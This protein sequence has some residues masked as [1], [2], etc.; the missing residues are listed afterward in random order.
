[1]SAALNPKRV[2]VSGSTGLIGRRLTQALRE[3]GA[4]VVPLLRRTDEHGM[5]SWHVDAGA[6]GFAS[7]SGFDAVVHLAGEPVATGR[8]TARK[9]R[10]IFSSRVQGTESLVAALLQA[11]EPPRAFLCASGIN[12]YGDRGDALLDEA[13]PRGA[14]FLADVCEHWEAATDPL[15]G[16]CRVVLLRI[17]VVLAR[18]G[19]ALRRCCCLSGLA[20]AVAWGTAACT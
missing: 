16:V 12:V 8:W 3:S 1:M 11:K 10:K 2:L 19:G 17:G 6:T 7:L 5:I 9:K 15:R 4:E 20:L 14:G 18:E 13:Q